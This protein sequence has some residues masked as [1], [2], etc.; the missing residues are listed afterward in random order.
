VE[1][2]RLAVAGLPAGGM[3]A[4]AA[5]G[6]V[7]IYRATGTINFA[8]G[9][10]ATASAFV[11]DLAWTEHDLP[12]LVA[13]LAALAV[14]FAFGLALERLARAIGHGN[15]LAQVIATL[16]VQGVILAGCE[17]IFGQ[18]ARV[19]PTYFPSGSINVAGVFI[20]YDQL[21]VIVAAA[22]LSA[23]VGLALTRTGLGTS[24]RA[25]SQNRLAA[26]L[27]GLPVQRIE[28]ISWAAGTVLAGLAG[29]LLAPLLFL[30][31][32]RLSVFF[33]VKPLAAAVVGGLVSL[34]LAF[35]AGITIGVAEGVLSRYT[36]LPGLTETVPFVMM[37]AALLVRRSF[38]SE[39]SPAPLSK[40]PAIRPGTGRFWPGVTALCAMVAVV[41][42]LS[43]AQTVTLRLT[44]SFTLLAL[45][46]VVLTGWV[47][48]VSLAQG[49]F[50]GLG[51]FMAAT[52][53]NRA[54]LPFGV[55]LVAAPVCVV[56]FAVIVGLPAVRFR[57]LLLAVVT[58]AFGSL[59]SASLFEWKTFTGGL[60][61]SH[62][63]SPSLFGVDLSGDRYTFV[64]LAVG[65]LVFAGARNLARFRCG[66]PLFGVR[67][68]EDGAQALGIGVTATKLI[69]FGISGA[70][71]GLGGT[72]FGYTTGFVS[73]AQFTP[74]LSATIFAVTV[75][76]GVES[77][78]GAVLAGAIFTV[79]SGETVQLLASIAVIVVLVFLP[80]GLTEA[81]RRFIRPAIRRRG[82]DVV[83]AGETP[84][85]RQDEVVMAPAPR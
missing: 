44:I 25:V 78:W 13:A 69:A 17:R 18:E 45:S 48:Q 47:G 6:I 29:I 66:G 61:G 43:P 30:D 27:A 36:A 14:A 20:S 58:L 9:A 19:V 51:A 82:A 39:L 8:Q 62:L 23:T 81:R 49:A 4:L 54:G 60:D 42:A 46:L 2:V 55:V 37:L 83:S 53:G 84:V 59:C 28:G 70:I 67:E 73:G 11:F 80:G 75:V 26:S 12:V 65:G 57:G 77:L 38:R 5:L 35:G 3:Y 7:L 41:P 52:L 79:P 1:M 16:G 32:Y 63:P 22:A 85:E 74:V 15:V 34:P 24:V 10:V 68:S 76:A 40:N 71:A 56:P 64:C 33:L 31:T 21:A 72:L 50:F